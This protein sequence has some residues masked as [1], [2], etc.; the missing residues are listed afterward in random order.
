[1]RFGCCIG[2]RE[3]DLRMLKECGCDCFETSLTL[4]PGM[5]EEE[6]L[7]LRR[8]TEEIGLPCAAYN[9]MFPGNFRLLRGEECYAEIGDYLEKALS[10]AEL[11]G[12]SV[13]SL[14]S[15]GARSLYDGM[16]LDTAKERFVGLVREV[17]APTMKKHG[18]RVA[19][20]P[21]SADECSFLNNCKEVTEIVRA[22]RLPELG[23]LYDSYHAERG[24]DRLSGMGEY[25]DLILH[26]HVASVPRARNFPDE[27]DL[28]ACRALIGALKGIGYDGTVDLECVP[29][30]PL[31]P[32]VKTAIAV[33]K[34]AAA[35][36]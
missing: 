24:G 19:V 3:A 18:F 12:G 36:A 32:A 8:L 27:S 4:M 6:L 23:L 2:P 25:G 29:S 30:G 14:G 34:S 15:G 21:L 17:I 33:L 10:K 16:D 26:V 20:E 5:Q 9:C 11:L 13:I 28:P 7:R 35:D 31:A 22:A 1:M